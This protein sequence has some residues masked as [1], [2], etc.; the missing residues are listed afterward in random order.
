MPPSAFMR[1]NACVGPQFPGAAVP[2]R[3]FHTS[4]KLPPQHGLLRQRRGNEGGTA[5]PGR[6]DFLPRKNAALTRRRFV[7]GTGAG[8]TGILAAGRA[9]AFAQTAAKKLVYAHIV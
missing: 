5:M 9:P 2:E 4:L 3:S 8:L 1:V 6:H 7:A